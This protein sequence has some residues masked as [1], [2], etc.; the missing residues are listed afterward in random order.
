MYD[1]IIP[2]I[3]LMAGNII[4]FGLLPFSI[5]AGVGLIWIGIVRK[6]FAAVLAGIT[7][8]ATTAIVGIALREGA[9]SNPLA[10]STMAATANSYQFVLPYTIGMAAIVFLVKMLPGIV[11]AHRT[12]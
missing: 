7:I 9:L 4:L 10:P 2:P 6:R 5:A 12:A 11:R 3:Q 8:A 1:A